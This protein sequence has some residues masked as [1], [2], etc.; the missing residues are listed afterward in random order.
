[1]KRTRPS[2][3][4]PGARARSARSSAARRGRRPPA[5]EPK[6][7]DAQRALA[8]L[9][10]RHPQVAIV[11]DEAVPIQTPTGLKKFQ[12]VSFRRGRSR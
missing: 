9:E 1:M 11:R 8:W 5:T 2:A 4:T 6:D 10:R 3:T 7:A 12:P